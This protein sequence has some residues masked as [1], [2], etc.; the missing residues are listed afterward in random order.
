MAAHA[1]DDDAHAFESC[2]HDYAILRWLLRHAMMLP[3]KML[4]CLRRA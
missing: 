2:R 4:L 1:A 3:P